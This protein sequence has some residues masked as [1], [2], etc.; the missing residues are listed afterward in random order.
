MVDPDNDDD[1][2]LCYTLVCCTSPPPPPPPPPLAG[3]VVKASTS[4][5]EHPGFESR[6]RWDFS[7][8]S[9]TSGLQIGTQMSAPPGAWR[10]RVSAGT[11]RSGVSILGLDK[12]K[13]LICNFYLSVAARK[14]LFERIRP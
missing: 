3:L 11:G 9:H 5:A 14:N 1:E 12:V 4:G 7:G 10:F 13:S 8:S 6:L 2:C